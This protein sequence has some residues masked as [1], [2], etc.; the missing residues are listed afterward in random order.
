MT[1]IHDGSPPPLL[2]PETGA[3][4]AAASGGTDEPSGSMPGDS[5]TPPVRGVFVSYDEFE[6]RRQLRRRVIAAF[7]KSQV[8]P[9]VGPR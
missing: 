8:V 9:P 6:K 4:G 3:E 7:E 5:V 2:Q 1:R